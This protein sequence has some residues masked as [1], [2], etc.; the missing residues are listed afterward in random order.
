[1]LVLPWVPRGSTKTPETFSGAWESWLL[2]TPLTFTVTP[3]DQVKQSMDWRYHQIQ[4][5][6]II[7]TSGSLLNHTI[8]DFLSSMVCGDISNYAQFNKKRLLY[9]SESIPFL[10]FQNLT[11]SRLMLRMMLMISP[12]WCDLLELRPPIWLDMTWPRPVPY[13]RWAWN[14]FS[15]HS[16]WCWEASASF[17]QCISAPGK[18]S[19]RIGDNIVNPSDWR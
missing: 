6:I 2:Q 3:H 4:E 11:Q 18:F 9:H 10:E 8:F 19:S 12:R 14:S 15:G 1:M 5:T 16:W 13:G 7:D 17:L